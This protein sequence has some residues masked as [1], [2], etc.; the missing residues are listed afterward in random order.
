M[1]GGSFLRPMAA[2]HARSQ[3]VTLDGSF[4]RSK[5]ASHAWWQL[6]MLDDSFSCSMAASQARWQLLILDGGFSRSMTS[7][8]LPIFA[9][10]TGMWRLKRNL[11]LDETQTCHVQ[12]L[13]SSVFT[14]D[15]DLRI[16]NHGRYTLFVHCKSVWEFII[17]YTRICSKSLILKLTSFYYVFTPDRIHAHR[18]EK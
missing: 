11:G 7:S 18:D 12:M 8:L 16:W 10:C 1:L 6:L 3:L 17:K 9:L 5:A 15:Y 13:K 2:C 4:S 14:L